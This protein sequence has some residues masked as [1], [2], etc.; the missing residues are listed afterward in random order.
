[1]KKTKDLD[2]KVRLVKQ[3]KNHWLWLAWAG[4]THY[5]EGESMGSRKD[6]H[7]EAMAWVREVTS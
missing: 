6:A 7:D 4:S 5:C 2:I 1:M 3:S